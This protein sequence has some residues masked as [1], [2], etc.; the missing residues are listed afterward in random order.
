MLAAA[1]VAVAA[2]SKLLLSVAIVIVA[3]A[4]PA[5]GEASG[6]PPPLPMPMTRIVDA[7]GKASPPDNCGATTPTYTMI[8]LAV[9]AS[10]P[11]DTVNVCPGTY[12]EQVSFGPT[13][14]GITLRSLDFRAAVIKAPLVM[15]DPGDIVTINGAQNITLRDFTVAGPLPDSLFCSVFLRTGVRVIGG[16]SA[17]IQGNHVTEIRSTSP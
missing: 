8:Q 11:G 17:I 4:G 1:L 13:K 7:D 14:I 6:A 10:G 16:G 15:T 12:P 3:V 9:D 2:V 5:A